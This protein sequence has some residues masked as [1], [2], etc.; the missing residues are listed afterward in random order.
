MAVD[1]TTREFERR[2]YRLTYRV[3][4][5]S[6]CPI[7]RMGREVDDV[8]IF[9]TPDD[10]KCDFTVREDGKSSVKHHRRSADRRCPCSVFF[11]TRAV[12]HVTLDG[13]DL[14]ITTYVD[15]PEAGYDIAERL[16]SISEDVSLVDFRRVAGEDADLNARI[17]LSALTKKQLQAVAIALERGY[18]RTPSETTIEEMAAETDVSSSAFATR[19][20]NAEQA[21]ADQLLDAI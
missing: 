14:R 2:E 18:Y 17:D 12:P 5:P 10:M 21:I 8:S 1:E 3:T 7:E 9:R 15:E 6:T 11:E 20:R 19:L 4:P 16:K 13:E